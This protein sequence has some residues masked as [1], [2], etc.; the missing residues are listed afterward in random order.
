MKIKLLLVWL[1]IF[2]IS[3]SCFTRTR[4]RNISSPFQI[5][6][7]SDELIVLDFELGDFTLD[8][9]PL[10][11]LEYHF[12]NI[13]GASLLLSE[14]KP[15]IPVFTVMLAIPFTGSIVLETDQETIESLSDILLRPCQPPVPEIGLTSDTFIID[16]SYYN[17]NSTYPESFYLLGDPAVIRDLR[18][19]TLQV[20][21]FQ[22]NPQT[23]ELAVLQKARL[24][25]RVTR[26]EGENEKYIL[27]KPSRSFSNLYTSLVSNSSRFLR[28]DEFQ[29]PCYLFIY[30]QDNQVVQSLQPL[31]DWKADKGF[32]VHS[33]S[34][35][36][37]GTSLT[38]I[39][40]YIQNAYDYWENPPEFVCLVGDAGG[41]FNI[42][43]GH[44]DGGSYN[45]EGDH[46]YTT[47]EGDD[48]LSDIFIGRLS[49]NTIFELQT[50]IAKTINYEKYPYTDN[51]DWY[52]RA[53]LVGDPSSSGP[54]TVDTKMNVA[55]MINWHSPNMECIEVY[56]GNW[57]NQIAAN[58]NN[59]VSYFNYRGF[60]GVSGWTNSHVN[61]LN[62][63]YMLPVAVVLTCVTGDFEGTSDCLSERFLKAGTPTLPKGAVAAISTATGN[64]HTCFN[65]CIDAGIFHGL[66]ADSLYNMGAALVRGKLNLHL[67][68]PDNPNNSVVKFSYWNNLMG[69]PGLELWT[70]IPQILHAD[71]PASVGLGTNQLQVEVT[72][73]YGNPLPD[74]WV[75]VRTAG[76][77]ISAQGLTDASGT[78]ILPISSENPGE[79]SLVVSKHNFQPHLGNF[80]IQSEPACLSLA[81]YVMDDDQTGSS[82][83]NNDG[84]INP[85]ETIELGIALRNTGTQMVD[86][87]Y[88]ILSCISPG[89]NII[90]SQQAYGTLAAGET[91][92]SPLAFCFEADAA[93]LG[94]I[95]LEF[96]LQIF[97]NNEVWNDR[98]FL[99]VFGPYL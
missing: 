92:F 73:N 81:E 99:P 17:S 59:G 26:Q 22:Y 14:G 21:P 18:V 44:M 52:D 39:R 85:G 29:Q 61:N 83:G 98:F 33:V 58:L 97:G 56:D 67:N 31:L 88:A 78:I 1:L 57:V 48:Y 54:S 76:N 23:R 72:D 87:V 60:A 53:L 62:N 10:A 95:S 90:T 25:L 91:V 74:A 35:T 45:G 65:N 66:F 38:A 77:E 82:S 8:K 19:V 55:E 3:G 42:P 7:E 68:Y 70:G 89:V 94:G 24:K 4:E 27:R 50:I 49:F 5:S 16:Q 64:T 84:L 13:E 34:T 37:T 93:L 9:Q 40:N 46:Y 75:A 30:P 80:N 69:D 11:N 79:V 51:P 86:D 47:L 20:S 2:M 96:R 71:Y 36:V 15:E 43:T 41:S 32:E 63:G 12:I 28:T 6:S